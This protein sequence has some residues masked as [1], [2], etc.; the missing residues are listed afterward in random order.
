M[1]RADIEALL[2]TDRQ[3]M[4]LEPSLFDAAIIGI[5]ERMDGLYAIAYD[6]EKCIAITEGMG[7]TREEAEE[8]F[9]FNTA[10]A[11]VGEGTPVFITT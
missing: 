4:L 2:D 3:A 6:R 11:W 8:Y 10:G 7:M 1:N 9:E 5:A